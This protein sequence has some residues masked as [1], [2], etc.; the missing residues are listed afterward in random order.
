MEASV[1]ERYLPQALWP[2]TAWPEAFLE[3]YSRQPEVAVGVDGLG[4]GLPSQ[5]S[6]RIAEDSVQLTYTTLS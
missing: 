4:A 3:P 2:V 1:V 5:P 6:V